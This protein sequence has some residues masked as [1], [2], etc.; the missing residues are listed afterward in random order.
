MKRG[1]IYWVNLEPTQ[2]SEIRK[3][4]PCVVVGA[5]PIN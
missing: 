1:D 3:K 5:T 2:G 4:R